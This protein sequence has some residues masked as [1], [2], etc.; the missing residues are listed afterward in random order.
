MPFWSAK[1]QGGKY[2]DCS[3]V[4]FLV[5]RFDKDYGRLE[6]VLVDFRQLYCLRELIRTR[7]CSVLL[8][9]LCPRLKHKQL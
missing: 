8:L 2:S 1:K 9:D 6:T 4:R 5:P 3:F 7:I